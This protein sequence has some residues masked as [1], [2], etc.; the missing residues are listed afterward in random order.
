MDTGSNKSLHIKWEVIP[1]SVKRNNKRFRSAGE[2]TKTSSSQNPRMSLRYP[3][4]SC[5]NHFSKLP[6]HIRFHRHKQTTCLTEKITPAVSLRIKNAAL[7]WIQHLDIWDQLVAEASVKSISQMNT[8]E[9][10]AVYDNTKFLLKV[11]LC[12]DDFHFDNNID[13]EHIEEALGDIVTA[14]AQYTDEIVLIDRRDGSLLTSDSSSS[15]DEE[16]DD[17]DSFL[18]FQRTRSLIVISCNIFAV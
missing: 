16:D 14:P 11:P 13:A 8:Q 1:P 6:E 15:D 9:L 18:C 5:G 3:C 2:T 10:D 4:P 7:F 17:E 12:N